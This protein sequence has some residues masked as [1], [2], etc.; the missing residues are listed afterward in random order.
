M[1]N[2]AWDGCDEPATALNR[3]LHTMIPARV[4]RRLVV[5]EGMDRGQSWTLD[6]DAPSRV[7]LGTSP[8]CEVRLT[9]TTVSRR[10]AAFEA[11]EGRFRISDL[12]TT[13][14]TFV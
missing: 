13:N 5:V 11:V 4:D 1:V 14:G 3:A 8:A 2:T 7:L 9:D 6:P 12:D 10:H